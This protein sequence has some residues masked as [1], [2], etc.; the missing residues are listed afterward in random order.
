MLIRNCPQY[1]LQNCLQFPASDISDGGSAS[2]AQPVQQLACSFVGGIQAVSTQDPASGLGQGS[3]SVP[4]SKKISHLQPDGS[5]LHLGSQIS[6]SV[7][8]RLIE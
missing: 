6:I 2:E 7:K 8:P 4:P 5:V 1:C 3:A